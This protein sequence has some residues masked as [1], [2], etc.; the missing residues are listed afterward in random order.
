MRN[1]S[2]IVTEEWL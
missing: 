2:T 1:D